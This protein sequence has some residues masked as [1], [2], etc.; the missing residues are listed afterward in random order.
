M[1]SLN[2]CI[3]RWNE[4]QKLDGVPLKQDGNFQ[5]TFLWY[6]NYPPSKSLIGEEVKNILN[7]LIVTHQVVCCSK[8][9]I[10]VYNFGVGTANI[11]SAWHW[12]CAWY[13]RLEIMP[14]L[15]IW[16]LS[17]KCVQ[18]HISCEAVLELELW[19]GYSLNPM[20]WVPSQKLPYK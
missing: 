8:T 2:E 20:L 14:F 3:W 13:G 5:I 7:R 15:Q 9:I 19:S 12:I 4:F 10:L 6:E 18:G 11:C 1:I 17:S 16:T